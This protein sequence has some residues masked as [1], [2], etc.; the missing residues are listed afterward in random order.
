MVY[1]TKQGESIKARASELKEEV[2]LMFNNQVGPLDQLELIDDLQKLGLAYHFQ[3]DINCT[4]KMIHNGRINDDNREK[5]LHATALEYRL[6]RQHG[7]YTSPGNSIIK[8]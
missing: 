8:I 3:E 6:L 5:D 1:C 4:L 2:R 7:Y